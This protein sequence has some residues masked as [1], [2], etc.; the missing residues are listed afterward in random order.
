MDLFRDE[1]AGLDEA[2][3]LAFLALDRPPEQ[4]PAEGARLDYKREEPKDLGEHVAAMANAYGGLIILGVEAVGTAPNALVGV[5][6]GK[7]EADTRLVNIIATTVNPVPVIEPKVVPLRR[8]RGHQAIVIRVDEGERPPYMFIGGGKNVIPIREPGSTR[9]ASLADIESLYRK[10]DPKRQAEIRGRLSNYPLF[11]QGR[12]GGSPIHAWLYVALTP[13]ADFWVPLHA[14][15]ERNLLDDLHRVAP[16]GLG[17]IRPA[18][19]RGLEFIGAD[20]RDA[21]HQRHRAWR[22]QR[23]GTLVH[24]IDATIADNV[25][26]NISDMILATHWAAELARATWARAGFHGGGA[27]HVRLTGTRG[28]V[29]SLGDLAAFHRDPVRAP[30]G[31]ALP[32]VAD[33]SIRPAYDADLT[34]DGIRTPLIWLPDAFSD[35]LRGLIGAIVDPDAFTAGVEAV[36]RGAR[37]AT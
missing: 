3:L 9:R 7:G 19:C 2:K 30:D 27:V 12:P 1:L 28:D 16:N 31:W 21:A 25:T 20:D 17:P 37:R 29:L 5:L 14:K 18:A 32:M 36:L 34:A 26:I 11:P 4:R 35:H 24:A 33:G 6:A 10:R 23:D 15:A 8:K 13:A 22:V